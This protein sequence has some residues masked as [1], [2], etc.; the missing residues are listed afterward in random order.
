MQNIVGNHDLMDFSVIPSM[1][2]LV[3]PQF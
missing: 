2:Y 1:F 3:C